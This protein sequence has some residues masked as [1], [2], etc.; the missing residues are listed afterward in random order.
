MMKSQNC[1][2]LKLLGSL[3]QVILLAT[4]F[5]WLT[6]CIAVDKRVYV[7]VEPFGTARVSVT[8]SSETKA[9]GNQ[10]TADPSVQL[11]PLPIP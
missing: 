10:L 7:T 5:G 1:D 3:W 2:V 6:G 4:L 11:G 8:N 9:D